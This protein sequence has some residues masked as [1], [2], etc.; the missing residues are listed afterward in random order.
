MNLEVPRRR[1]GACPEWTKSITGKGKKGGIVQ[2]KLF[3]LDPPPATASDSS[4]VENIR[5]ASPAKRLKS[6]SS[7][8]SIGTSFLGSGMSVRTV[9]AS[10]ESESATSAATSTATAT[11]AVM[12]TSRKGSRLGGDFVN[13]GFIEGQ[14]N[15]G[16][17]CP[18]L[19][20]KRQ[21]QE[22]NAEAITCNERAKVMKMEDVSGIA[23]TQQAGVDSIKVEA[24]ME[25]DG[26]WEQHRKQKAQRSK[27]DKP[28]PQQRTDQEAHRV[29]SPSLLS[30]SS[31]S[32]SGSTRIGVSW[33]LISLN[34]LI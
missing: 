6:S 9:P 5:S 8:S 1:S 16:D 18:L 3:S 33:I 27:Q 22:L 10:A 26:Y 19:G 14:S 17:G 34:S 23:E 32:S 29:E 4:G 2:L 25:D 12:V 24:T 15:D 30:S 28:R 21:S 11:A 13:S 31:L 20:F 7:Y